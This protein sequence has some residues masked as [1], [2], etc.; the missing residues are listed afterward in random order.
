MSKPRVVNTTR[1][2]APPEA[3]APIEEIIAR[4]Q[5]ETEQALATQRQESIR[6]VEGC[7]RRV[8]GLVDDWT[9]TRGEIEALKKTV[10][11][12]IHD[13]R[14]SVAECLNAQRESARSAQAAQQSA[15]VFDKLK[16]SQPDFHRMVGD[17]NKTVATI[18]DAMTHVEER[19][20]GVEKRL[21][22]FDTV[23]EDYE[24]TKGAVRGLDVIV[25]DVHG[26]LQQ[27]RRAGARS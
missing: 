13:M 4:F 12:A 14:Q 2:G 26:D 3:P 25:K 7:E 24:E 5:I 15:A 23:A 21:D 18:R 20:R 16:A 8:A 6:L 9:R 19:M 10:E 17:Q 22:E 1:E 11:N 27:R